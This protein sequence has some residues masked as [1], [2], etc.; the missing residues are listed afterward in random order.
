MFTGAILAS[1]IVADLRDAIKKL[2][3]QKNPASSTIYTGVQ[4]EYDTGNFLSI[5]G[6]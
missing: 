6:N 2:V 5:E 1:P 3:F 4:A